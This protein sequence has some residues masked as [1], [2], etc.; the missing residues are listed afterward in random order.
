MCKK[1]H[2]CGVRPVNGNPEGMCSQCHARVERERKL[3]RPEK[4]FRYVTYRG[5]VVAMFRNQ[6][7]KLRPELSGINPNR[8]PKSITLNLN[9]YLDG[10][11]RSQIK[12]LKR[13]VQELVHV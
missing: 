8:L 5:H 13:C 12:K 1:C 7:G 9:R 6:D 11:D 3:R 2:I 4:P 10:F